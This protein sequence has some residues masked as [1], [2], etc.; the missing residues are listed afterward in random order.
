MSAGSPRPCDPGPDLS[1]GFRALKVWATL[2]V[3]GT[4]AIGAVVER[5]CELARYLERRILA[6]TEL[7]LMAPVELNIVCFRYR[8]DQEELADQ[9]NRQIVIQLQEQ[10]EVAPS[11]TI[12]GGR[13][14][15]RAAVVNHRTTQI[16]MDTLLAATLSCRP[17]FAGSRGKSE[18]LEAWA[19]A[20]QRDTAARCPTRPT[21][22]FAK[23]G[24]SH[25][26]V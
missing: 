18:R 14:S 15:I 1:R 7:E 12:I 4:T 13:M 5:S 9:L 21:G 24:G 10:G 25:A 8:F 3:F 6:T 23:G 17:G 22:R 19:R 2:K 20:L 26:A 16:E 11:T